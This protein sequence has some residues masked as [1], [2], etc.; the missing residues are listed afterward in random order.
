MIATTDATVE[1][2]AAIEAA[3]ADDPVLQSTAA[4]VVVDPAATRAAMLMPIP[5]VEATVIGSARIATRVV[6]EEAT[7]IEVTGQTEVATGIEVTESGNVI[8][9]LDPAGMMTTG[10][11]T[12]DQ[13]AMQKTA[14]DARGMPRESESAVAVR[15]RHL[16]SASLLPT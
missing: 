13:T 4:V 10:D 5:P 7:E 11:Q 14:A 8:A 15:R 12:V 6:T 2:P 1:I 9:G 3:A 16:R